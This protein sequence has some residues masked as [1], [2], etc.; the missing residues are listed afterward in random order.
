MITSG[1]LVLRVIF[2]FYSRRQRCRDIK[3][4][5]GT[6]VGVNISFNLVYWYMYVRMSQDLRWTKYKAIGADPVTRRVYRRYEMF[7]AMRKLGVQ[8]S[9]QV[10]VTGFV[11]FTDSPD[12]FPGLLPTIVLFILEIV[13]ER[14]GVTGIK[15]ESAY[16]LFAFWGLSPLLP[17]FIIIVASVT[18]GQSWALCR[19]E[20][21]FVCDRG[22]SGRHA[23]KSRIQSITARS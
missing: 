19:E 17:A 4:V 11:F 21:Q 10:L 23:H 18:E 3:G 13:W 20:L 5:C 8:F 9:L 12:Y 14:L 6:M 15:D 16:R 2:E 7:S 1:A 22:L